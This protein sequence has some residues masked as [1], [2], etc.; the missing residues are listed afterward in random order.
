MLWS[1]SLTGGET[2]APCVGSME[3]Q[4]LDHR[5]S[6]LEIF[7]EM[8]VFEIDALAIKSLIPGTYTTVK[9]LKVLHLWLEV[10]WHIFFSTCPL[11]ATLTWAACLLFCAGYFA[12]IP[13]VLSRPFLMVPTVTASHYFS[14]S[15]LSVTEWLSFNFG[16]GI[17]CNFNS[18]NIKLYCRKGDFFHS[19]RASLHLSLRNYLS[20]ERHLLTRQETL[21]GRDAWVESRRIRRLRRTALLTVSGFT[22][23]GWNSR[24]SLASLLLVSYLVWLE[25]FL[26]AQASVSQDGFQHEGFWETSRHIM[27]WHVLR[28]L[29]QPHILPAIFHWQHCS[30]FYGDL[31][32]WGN[33]GK[34][35]LSFLAKAGIFWQQLPN[36]PMKKLKPKGQK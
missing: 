6:L 20:K 30:F 5:G 23:T 32:L 8:A 21:L 22:V 9:K 10:W 24:L 28:P 33:S 25:Y 19:T 34:W 31:L 35:L 17:Q 12:V 13:K 2:Q 1:S 7:T 15:V 26:V 36:S 4:P 16:T 27:G 3:S 18:K 14:I 29:S 11:Q